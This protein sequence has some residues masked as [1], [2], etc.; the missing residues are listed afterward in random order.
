MQGDIAGNGCREVVGLRALR[1]GVPAGKRVALTRGVVR[2]GG[3]LAVLDL[4][5]GDLRAL[6]R[7]KRHSVRKHR[8]AVKVTVFDGVTRLD[9]ILRRADTR[10]ST[11][12][13]ER[14]I[15]IGGIPIGAK[16]A[17]VLGLQRRQAQQVGLEIGAAGVLENLLEHI[18]CSLVV[19]ILNGN[20]SQRRNGLGR[21]LRIAS[22][23]RQ[24]RHTGRDNNR[25]SGIGV[26]DASRAQDRQRCRNVL[27]GK[28]GIDFVIGITLGIASI[29]LAR[30]AR[31]DGDLRVVLGLR[32]LKVFGSDNGAVARL[33]QSPVLT[34]HSIIARQVDR[35]DTQRGRI[36]R[37]LV[38][39]PSKIAVGIE[40]RLLERMHASRDTGSVLTVQNGGSV[41]SLGLFHKGK[42]GIELVL[43]LRGDCDIKGLACRDLGVGL[44]GHREGDLGLCRLGARQRTEDRAPVTVK[45][46]VVGAGRVLDL[47]VLA[48][49]TE[50][51][52]ARHLQVGS[53]AILIGNCVGTG[54]LDVVVGKGGINFRLQRLLVGIDLLG[55]ALDRYGIVV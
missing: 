11:V 52:R 47:V 4:L 40:V 1:I 2:L 44:V 35:N 46:D 12:D 32:N 3:R 55:V 25:L 34:G 20:L 48:V 41:A 38:V 49:H 22:I 6:A 16:N 43:I 31:R 42:L 29:L 18:L 45:R 54:V 9:D 50:R 14:P 15:A 39:T 17:T 37:R 33:K 28:L 5:R 27:I 24:A 23:A 19:I 53:Q 26:F 36:G 51:T 13:V 7:I 10:H 8:K 21:A 30:Q